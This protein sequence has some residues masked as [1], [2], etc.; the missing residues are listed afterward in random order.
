MKMT[1]EQYL[2]EVKAYLEK[3]QLTKE[4]IQNLMSACRKDIQY[5]YENNWTIPE[6]AVPME[7]NL[8]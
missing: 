2:E 4:H 1:L 8:I 5:A 3:D 7:M 6:I